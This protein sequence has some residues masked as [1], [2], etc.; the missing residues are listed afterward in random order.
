MQIAP[1]SKRGAYEPIAEGKT[2]AQWGF[3]RTVRL[4]I[5]GAWL[6]IAILALVWARPRG[7][8]GGGGGGGD[9]TPARTAARMTHAAV[10][11]GGSWLVVAIDATGADDS[12]VAA[13]AAYSVADTHVSGFGE[14][15][16][17]TTV[18]SGGRFFSDEDRAFAA[19]LLEGYL[20]AS[21]INARK[22]VPFSSRTRARLSAA[23]AVEGEDLCSLCACA[24]A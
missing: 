5:A 11:R 7:G 3:R 9:E 1:I 2:P 6:T 23:A 4:G 12:A 18:S 19:G 17:R 14:L 16:V 22:A 8:G 20:T 21:E 13:V 24:R 15:H 10:R